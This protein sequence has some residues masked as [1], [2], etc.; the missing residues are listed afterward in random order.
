MSVFPRLVVRAVDKALDGGMLQKSEGVALD[1][2]A[3]TGL[4][5]VN[6]C[7]KRLN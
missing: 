6:G 7:Q 1:L 5:S 3:T 4:L 2:Q